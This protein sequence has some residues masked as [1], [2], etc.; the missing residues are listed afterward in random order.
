MSSINERCIEFSLG[1]ETYALPLNIVKEVI[2]K[3]Q[4]TP[5]PN[6]PDY[7]LGIINLR[8]TIVT[9]IDLRKKMK[10]KSKPTEEAII[11]L[12][13]N[14]NFVGIIVDSINKVFTFN[15]DMVT[16]VPEIGGE[17]NNKYIDAIYK[18]DNHLTVILNINEIFQ[19]SNKTE[20][21]MVA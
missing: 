10:I 21:K 15:K 4:S 7:N 13:L 5:I 2:S 19:L 6:S 11:V 1:G 3:T 9:I 8:G 16:E 20:I 17:I 14:N 18:N 12:E